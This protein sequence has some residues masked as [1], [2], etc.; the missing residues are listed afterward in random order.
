MLDSTLE[1]IGRTWLIVDSVLDLLDSFLDLLDL[2]SER[3]IP[4][5][6]YR[7]VASSTITTLLLC[8]SFSLASREVCSTVEGSFCYP[9]K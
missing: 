5:A 2:S 7:N 3:M 8:C 9:E 1:G 4:R 6:I